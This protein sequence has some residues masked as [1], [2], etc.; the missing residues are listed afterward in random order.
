MIGRVKMFDETRGFGFI[1]GNDGNDYFVHITEVKSAESLTTG[2]TVEFE[3]GENQ[4]GKAAKRV[5]IVAYNASR[6]SFVD[7][8]K[9]R[10]RFSNIKNYGIASAPVYYAKVFVLVE[11]EGKSKLFGKY[12]YKERVDSG[13][14]VRLCDTSESDA[15]SMLCDGSQYY[16][17]YEAENGKINKVHTGGLLESGPVSFED[18]VECKNVDYLYVT[19]YQKDNY[20]FFADLTEFDIHSK[21]KEI[22]GYML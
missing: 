4:K 15:K 21:C 22:D 20:R 12:R 8:G 9:T 3:P 1:L 14:R 6:P 7:F 16:H 13:R 10:I 5:A 19:T 2:T 18:L 11:K 17:R